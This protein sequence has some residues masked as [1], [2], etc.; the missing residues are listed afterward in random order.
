MQFK[1]MHT[2]TYKPC[3]AIS[4]VYCDIKTR[5]LGFS[6]LA[7]PPACT[8][9]CCGPAFSVRVFASARARE[10]ERARVLP[11]SASVRRP[12][13]SWPRK[14]NKHITPSGASEI[15]KLTVAGAARRRTIC[16]SPLFSFLPRFAPSVDSVH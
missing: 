10:R 12:T 4:I 6:Y 14:I 3:R 8:K 11:M 5:Q 9:Q 15:G 7:F 2:Q 13:S 1:H 16:S